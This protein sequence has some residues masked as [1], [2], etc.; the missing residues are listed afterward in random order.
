MARRGVVIGSGPNGLAGAIVLARAGFDVVVHE[1]AERAGGGVRSEELTLPGFV[2]DVC[3][4]V[5]PLAVASPFFRELDLDVEW[6]HPEAP[7]AHPLDDGSA[8]VLERGLGETAAQLGADGP[9][10][11]RLL[12]PVLAA[13]SDIAALRPL[14]SARALGPGPLRHA[15]A[16][17]RSLAE[18]L[19]RGEP[20]R[21][22]FAGQSAHSMLPLERRPSA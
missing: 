12:R 10:Y 1:A 5:H 17:A 4:A 19:F 22:L 21:A 7:A 9:A 6:V 3:S 11:E 20:A 18:E 16:A 14:A 13:W 2:H 15:L 8:V